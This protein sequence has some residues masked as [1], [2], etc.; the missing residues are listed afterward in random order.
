VWTCPECDRKF[1]R[2]NQGHDCAPGLTVEEYFETGPEFEPPIFEAVRDFF[3]AEVDPDIYYE[4]VS[5]GI[6][7]KRRT[8]FLS[9]RTMTK[10]VAVGFNLRRRVTSDRISRKVIEHGDKFHH[11][12]N[13]K[14]TAE[15]DDQLTAWLAEA[16]EAD[17]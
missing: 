17:A 15:I 10:W 3:Q 11:V 9:L 2:T 6:F 16:W 12:V 14:E 5:V 4:P 13:V 1:G 8:T 7:F